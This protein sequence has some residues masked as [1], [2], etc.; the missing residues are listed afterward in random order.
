MYKRGKQKAAFA[1]CFGGRKK[2]KEFKKL[3]ANKKKKR[4][5]KKKNTHTQHT[6]HTS[7]SVNLTAALH[8]CGVWF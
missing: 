7:V 2:E 8:E 4:R 6:T 1:D 3:L 5:R